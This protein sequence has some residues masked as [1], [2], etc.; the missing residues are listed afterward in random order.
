METEKNRL[1]LTKFMENQL[2]G[3][4]HRRKSTITEEN[5]RISTVIDED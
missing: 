5:I 3:Q 1:K 2:N 4:N